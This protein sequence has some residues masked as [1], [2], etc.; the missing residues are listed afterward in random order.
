MK[1]LII[2]ILTASLNIFS[3]DV[4]VKISAD[5]SEYRKIYSLNENTDPIIINYTLYNNT[6]DSILIKYEPFFELDRSSDG[7][8]G[9]SHCFRMD[10]VKINGEKVNR[11]YKFNQYSSFVKVAPYD[12][13]VY[14]GEFDIFWPCRSAP[15]RGDWKF[16]VIYRNI[17]TKDENYYLVNSRYTDFASKEFINAWVGE[18]V[19]N[20]ISFTILREN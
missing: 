20:T 2:I 6:A 13:L 10:P 9:F 14:V 19:S 11:Y 5:K 8:E 16:N 17:L 15:P 3:Q 12:S 7:F 1:T 4:S 18:L